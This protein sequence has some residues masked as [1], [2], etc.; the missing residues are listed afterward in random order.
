MFLLMM[1]GTEERRAIFNPILRCQRASAQNQF[2][3]RHSYLQVYIF[4]NKR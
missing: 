1:G 3:F 4:S 2:F